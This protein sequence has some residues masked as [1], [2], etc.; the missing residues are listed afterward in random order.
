MGGFSVPGRGCPG[1]AL[2]GARRPLEKSPLRCYS[3]LGAENAE[4]SFLIKPTGETVRK[5]IAPG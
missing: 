3:P 5:R 2:E 1:N 4:E